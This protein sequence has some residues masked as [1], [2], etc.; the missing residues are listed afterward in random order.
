MFII[1]MKIYVEN[2]L[3]IEKALPNVDE[4]QP[5]TGF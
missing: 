5:E 3:K 4:L 1:I 2:D